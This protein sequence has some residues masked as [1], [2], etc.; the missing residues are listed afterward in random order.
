MCFSIYEIPFF[1]LS[2][3]PTYHIRPAWFEFPGGMGG[4]HKKNPSR[5][6]LS[7]FLCGMPFL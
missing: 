2:L 1:H 5:S 7:L 3:E 4:R 6:F